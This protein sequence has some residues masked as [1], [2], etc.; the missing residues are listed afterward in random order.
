MQIVSINENELERFLALNDPND[1]D[2]N[3]LRTRI[4]EF[5]ETGH[6]RP[7]WC[8]LAQENGIDVGR[9]AYELDSTP[10][11]IRLFAV[12]LPWQADYL[13]VG[14]TLLAESLQTMA[15]QGMQRAIRQVN[16]TWETAN[17]ERQVLAD[18]GFTLRQAKTAFVL[19]M[20]VTPVVVPDR[21]TYR[22]LEEV[23]ETAFIAAVREASTQTLDHDDQK[24][25]A[26]VGLQQAA[27]DFFTLLQDDYWA[28]Q[29]GWWQV[30]YTPDDALVG[31]VQPLV[32]RENPQEGTIGYI[33]VVPKQ[34]GHHYVDDLLL[35]AHHIWQVAG[36][37][38]M[39]SDTDIDNFPMIG[40]FQRV[41]YQDNGTNW[42]Y[43][44]EFQ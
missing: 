17:A 18:A 14:K 10:Q 11:H 1:P 7:G 9:V 42:I 27:A 8:F 12:E 21:L 35:K 28:Y 15:A 26:Q 25:I 19:T 29:P 40:A 5:W 4:L 31:F 3:T 41:G 20:P 36:V 2:V 23:G 33:G 39:Y 38:K 30:A 22:S 34:R 24:A 32:F 44:K 43:E 16:S 37:Q 13:A 6:S